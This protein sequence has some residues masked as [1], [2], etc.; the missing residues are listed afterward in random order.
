MNVGE[1]LLKLW[2]DSGFYAIF[3]GFTAENG[4]QSLVMI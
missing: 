1:I 3:A 2:S 4:W